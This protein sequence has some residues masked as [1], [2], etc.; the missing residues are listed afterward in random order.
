M[1]K[2]GQDFVQQG[3]DRRLKDDLF[4]L[5]RLA[6]R[7]DLDRSFDLTTVAMVPAEL[8]A[9]AEICTR[10]T[11]IAAGVDL[12]PW[13]IEAL[14]VSL[15]CELRIFDGKA[16]SPKQVL[17]ILRGSGRDIL[18][19]ERILLNLLGRLCGIA[20][21]TQAHVSLIEDLETKLYDTRKTTPGWR[22]LEK[23]A[24]RCGGAMNHRSGL[25]EAIMVKDN[26]LAC[27][28][29]R[30]GKL[31]SP[32]EVVRKLREFCENSHDTKP[33]TIIE[34]EVDT[35]EQLKEALD[36]QPD[37]VLLDNMSVQTLREAVAMRDSK[38]P[39]VQLEASGG[40]TQET[41]RAKADTG[42][43]RI[44][45]GALTHSAVNLDL[46]LDWKLQ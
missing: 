38:S 43:E 17:A 39:G 12:L 35:L 29:H 9:S 36:A 20:T 15:S 44:S 11:G 4:E 24:T 23:Y 21:W 41:L 18:T 22:R 33:D 8:K 31:L 16:F 27:D 10:S 40:I 3:K 45:L 26:H 37:I 28:A 30:T 7:E 34:I 19:C 32:I 46:G 42:V 2:P 13:M 1:L 5:I 6:V 14:D 25:Y